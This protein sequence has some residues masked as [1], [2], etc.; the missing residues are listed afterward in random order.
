MKKM[1]ICNI[2][3]TSSFRDSEDGSR[4]TYRIKLISKDVMSEDQGLVLEVPVGGGGNQVND[5]KAHVCAQAERPLPG[6]VP[7]LREECMVTC[8]HEY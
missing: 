4:S 6:P 7:G 3:S 8:N 5:E 1:T 2:V